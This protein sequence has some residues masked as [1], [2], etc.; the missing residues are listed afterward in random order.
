MTQAGKTMNDSI[1]SGT[2][3]P[4]RQAQI[5]FKAVIRTLL[6][7]KLA[8]IGMIIIMSLFSMAI[9]APFLTSY[10][11]IEP[12]FYNTLKGPSKE[13]WLGTDDLGRDLFSRIV[14]GARISMTVALACTI[15]SII[16][17]TCLGLLAGFKKGIADQVIM[18]L[19]DM[20]MVF[21]GLIFVLL[22]AAALGPGMGNIII[23]ITLFGWTAFARVI[24]GQV[25]SVREEPYVEAARAA[26]ASDLRI[27]FKY[28]LPN[29]MAPIIVMAAMAL[30]G[31][32]AIESGAAFLGI[33]V[34]P[35]T[36]TWGR[37]LRVGY[38]YLTTAPLFSIAPGTLITAA[39]LAFTFLGDGLRDALDPRIRGEGKK[40]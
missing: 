16:L 25:L 26:G 39:I 22:L 20:I 12:D 24:R 37:E 23:A 3:E 30:G 13:H 8:V 34:Q 21:P 11:P 7:H 1:S 35:P 29:S 27:M 36:P 33:G 5:G 40:L 4:R 31:S 32:V 28:V 10:D 38:A 19:V 9:F 14:Y 15:F 6:G 18:R 2:V 17:G